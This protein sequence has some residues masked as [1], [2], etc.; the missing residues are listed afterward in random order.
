M[1]DVDMI[2]ALSYSGKF[3][4]L[5]HLE[6]TRQNISNALQNTNWKDLDNELI[7][8]TAKAVLGIEIYKKSVAKN[9]SEGLR[10]NPDTFK[11]TTENL[12][13]AGQFLSER[14]KIYSPKLVPYS[15]QIVLLAQALSK[16]TNNTEQVEKNLELWVW[17]TAYMEEFSGINEN[18]M[19]KLL[20]EVVG[21]AEG[22]PYDMPDNYITPMSKSFNFSSVRAKLLMLRLA[23][24]NAIYPHDTGMLSAAEVLS[25]D[26]S[27]AI[28]RLLGKELLGEVSNNTPENCFI[29]ENNAKTQKEFKKH[30][31]EEPL[32]NTEMLMSHAVT[33]EAAMAL[34]Q[35]QY[36]RFLELRKQQLIHIE[37]N[38][39]K[40]IKLKY[41]N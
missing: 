29:I 16:I 35:R 7:L 6:Q 2:A 38:F 23:E 13:K 39:I 20:Q 31:L 19:G 25:R 18:Q 14:C 30:L 9:T 24:L 40:A 11:T 3:D 32:K 1:S 15:Y 26:N 17:R 27:K 34:N 37:G 21:L 41:E 36:Q 5:D 4:L 12:V 10:D 22:N 33:E 8:S 28:L